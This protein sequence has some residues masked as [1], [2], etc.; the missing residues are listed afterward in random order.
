M[1]K[2][3][4]STQGLFLLPSGYLGVNTLTPHFHFQEI[5]D[6]LADPFLNPALRNSHL[7]LKLLINP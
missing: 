7:I 3:S 4:N 1:G 6:T 2:S 5:I